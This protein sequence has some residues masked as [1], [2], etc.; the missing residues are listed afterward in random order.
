MKMLL[1][2][3]WFICVSTFILGYV[4]PAYII[5]S[6]LSNGIVTGYDMLLVLAV[7]LVNVMLALFPFLWM[8][9]S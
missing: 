8:K 1:W 3:L 4:L 9:R 6:Y 5:P 7:C 2:M